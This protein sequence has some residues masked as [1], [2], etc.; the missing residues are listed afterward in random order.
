RCNTQ[1]VAGVKENYIHRRSPA[2]HQLSTAAST[3]PTPGGRGRSAAEC[4]PPM[5]C[6]LF[7]GVIYPRVTLDTR[8]S[9]GRRR[10]R[11]R[12]AQASVAVTLCLL[13]AS[14][15]GLAQTPMPPP[16]AGST[17]TSPA[18]ARAVGH[19]LS[20]EEAI[21]IAL[22]TQP[23]I[24][25]RIS[26]YMAAAHREDQASAPLL[27]QI[28]GTY[29]AARTQSAVQS[30][31]TTVDPR[32]V[33]VTTLRPFEENTSGRVSLSQVLFDFGKTFAS[34]EAARRLAEQ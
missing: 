5:G 21:G 15:P 4:R 14:S 34:P 17:Q 29:I 11:M 7:S 33:T 13:A 31:R 28:T 23:Q 19:P 2:I 12:I 30:S 3:W 25:A 20:L 18:A 9:L 8:T 6:M 24:Q 26:D 27:P 22:E 32:G 10:R 16:A 1:D